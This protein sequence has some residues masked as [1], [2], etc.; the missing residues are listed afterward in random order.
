MHLILF[1]VNQAFFCN[2]CLFEGLKTTIKKS[3][4]FE[5]W[6]FLIYKMYFI[7]ISLMFRAVR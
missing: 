5:V 3:H 2:T 7:G 6:L 1:S 4:T